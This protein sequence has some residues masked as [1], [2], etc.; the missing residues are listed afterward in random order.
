MRAGQWVGGWER[1]RVGGGVDECGGKS[2]CERG[3]NV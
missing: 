2:T 3:N 1:D